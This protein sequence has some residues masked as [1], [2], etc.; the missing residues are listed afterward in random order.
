MIGNPSRE[1]TLPIEELGSIFVDPEAYADPTGWHASA[2]RIRALKPVLPVDLPG[3]PPFWAITKHADVMEV[4]RHPDVFTNSPVPIIVD[5]ERVAELRSTEPPVKALV[6]MDG[7][8]HKANRGIVSDW[9]KPGSVKQLQGRVDELA[10][11]A[12]DQMAAMRA[13]ATSPRTWRSTIRFR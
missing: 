10:T 6:Q 9:F 11:R 13:A 3:Y 8:Q 4:E 2:A 5:T 12:V 1:S 7:N